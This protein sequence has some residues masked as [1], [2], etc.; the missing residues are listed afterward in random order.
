MHLV[1][2]RGDCTRK[3]LEMIVNFDPAFNFLLIT[4][5]HYRHSALF[6]APLI[7]W[8]LTDQTRK[9]SISQPKLFGNKSITQ[10]NWKLHKWVQTIFELVSATNL[11]KASQMTT[12]PNSISWWGSSSGK[13]DFLSFG[14]INVHGTQSQVRALLHSASIESLI[15][16]RGQFFVQSLYKLHVCITFDL[17]SMNVL[18]NSILFSIRFSERMG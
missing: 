15:G 9:T 4:S 3:A 6:N 1:K 8:R 2:W 7:L 17:K 14:I 16:H 12:T 18:T 11:L 10:L 13:M 5:N